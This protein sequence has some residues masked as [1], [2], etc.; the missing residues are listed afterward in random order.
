MTASSFKFDPKTVTVK[1]G[2]PVTI[3]LKSKDIEHDFTVDDLKIHV[4]AGPGKLT[5]STVTPDKPGRYTFYCSV[6]GHR[7]AGMVGTLEVQP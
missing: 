2:Q 4:G 6:P 1:A 7:S 3:A 5:K